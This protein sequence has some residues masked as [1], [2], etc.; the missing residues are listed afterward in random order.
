MQHSLAFHNFL[1]STSS[2]IHLNYLVCAWSIKLI[3]NISQHINLRPLR[4]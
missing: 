1:L 4:L 2:F 3:I